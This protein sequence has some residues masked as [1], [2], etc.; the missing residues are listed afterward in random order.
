MM[1]KNCIQ[2]TITSL[3]LILCIAIWIDEGNAAIWIGT[4]VDKQTRQPIEGVAVGIAIHRRTA[5]PAGEVTSRACNIGSLSDKKGFFVVSRMRPTL[6]VPI[7]QGVETYYYAYK[8]GYRFFISQKK[9]T[10]KIDF[11]KVRTTYQDR[12]EELD[13]A[14]EWLG[15]HDS[16]KDIRWKEYEFLYNALLKRFPGVPLDKPETHSFGALP[17][18]LWMRIASRGNRIGGDEMCFRIHPD[19]HIFRYPTI[20]Q[21]EILQKDL[22][23]EKTRTRINALKKMGFL[24]D[25]SFV[26][27]LLEALKDPDKNIRKHAVWA[28]GLYR[29]PEILQKLIDTMVHDSDPKVRAEAATV[30]KQ[31][32]EPDAVPQLI[33]CLSTNS[34][35]LK[36]MSAWV[37]GEYP[38]HQHVI[39]AL[40]S[41]LDDDDVNVMKMAQ[42]ALVNIGP[43]AVP[44]LVKN[45]GSPNDFS[46]LKA[47]Q[48]IYKFN[49]PETKDLLAKALQSNNPGM[50]AKAI[51]GLRFQKAYDMA[52]SIARF[53]KSPDK[54]VR[55]EAASALAFFDATRAL[56]YLLPFLEDTEKGRNIRAIGSIIELRHPD[57]IAVIKR[58]LKHP[59]PKVREYTAGSFYSRGSE[60]NDLLD[61]FLTLARDGNDS[62]RYLA[63]MNLGKLGDQRATPVLL[64][65]L[66]NGSRVAAEAL[67]KIKDLRSIGPVAARLKKGK[68]FSWIVLA[69]MGMPALKTLIDLGESRKPA[70]WHQVIRGLVNTKIPEAISHANK[71]A[72][73][74]QLNSTDQLHFFNT[75]SADFRIRINDSEFVRH[76]L[77]NGCPVLQ[78]AALESFFRGKKYAK[79][80]PVVVEMLQNDTTDPKV[81]EKAFRILKTI[82]EPLV[83]KAV[84]DEYYTRFLDLVSRNGITPSSGDTASDNKIRQQKRDRIHAEKRAIWMLAK[85]GKV[86]AA[87]QLVGFLE[88]DNLEIRKEA[89]RALADLGDTA[90]ESLLTALSSKDSYLRWKCAMVLGNILERNRNKGNPVNMVIT[91][92]LE[93]LMND[94]S[95]EVRYIAGWALG[96]ACIHT[97]VESLSV[98]SNDADPGIKTM[99]NHVLTRL[100][101]GQNTRQNGHP[102]IRSIA[103]SF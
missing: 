21:I 43:N 2:R 10:D 84:S 78:E 62:D 73:A 55:L 15:E 42:Q 98:L 3:L 34:P 44:A 13:D 91:R 16:F 9:I 6:Y 88:S 26:K 57:T 79:L 90:V 54:N 83:Q 14:S 61:T 17:L 12:Q 19:K 70:V 82:K 46:S 85:S 92:S 39:Q 93:S 7:L 33:D 47:L 71:I 63:A 1:L 25:L 50:Q 41:V 49:T 23:S 51:A 68:P 31:N 27:S 18:S 8:P 77:K 102:V 36:Q 103:P 22:K 101:E 99:A 97:S 80:F 29:S 60:S 38:N 37:L 53:L 24:A 45:L 56:P 35:A 96:E 65:M 48:A 66:D 4:I 30:L 87:K 72:T 64:K 89:S 86:I 11:E 59:N 69:D 32:K 75:L 95:C 20:R 67:G 28:L 100:K 58:L 5:T 94:P 81:R 40:S 74:N 52:D 76:V